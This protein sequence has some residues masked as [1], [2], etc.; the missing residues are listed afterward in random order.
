M[1]PL[2]QLLCDCLQPSVPISADRLAVLSPEQ[3]Q[4]FMVL[5]AAQRV[6][7]LLWHRL[8]QK[9]LVEALPGEAGALLNDFFMMNTAKNLRR[10]AELRSLLT[11]LHAEGIPVILLKGIYLADA[12][13]GQ[14]GFREMCD[15]DLLVRPAD[16]DRV[17]AVLKTKGYVAAQSIS[18]EIIMATSHHLPPLTCDGHTHVEIHWNLTKPGK[19]YSSDP[20]CLWTRAVSCR[21]AAGEALAL[22]PEDLLLHLC[23]HTSYQHLF[24][25]GLR[26]FCDI[27]ATIE[28]FGAGIDWQAVVE[29]ADRWG[30]SRGVYL[31]LQLSR[32]LA[33]AKVP[34]VILAQMHPIDV[35][36][37]ILDVTCTQ[38]FSDKMA[39]AQV[40]EA[41]ASLLESRRL[42]D[43]LRIFGERVF[44]PKVTIAAMYSV[45]MDSAKIYGCYL[46]RIFDLLRRHRQTLHKYCR[47]DSGAL[48]AMVERKNRVTTWLAGPAADGI[49]PV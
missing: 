11:V 17:A 23:L 2:E 45:P 42:A 31:A 16:L 30:W 37:T 44:I 13:Y 21:T 32:M 48:H 20:A 40:P 35:D 36:E 34:D 43:R 14:I 29:R 6:R 41:Y 10:Y 49:P 1:E 9:R 12:V 28:S 39:D 15:I 5:A 22:S 38:V 26:P 19:S 18:C 25:F 3:W 46:H 33:G 27:A 47:D 4:A 7:P 24:V 8:K